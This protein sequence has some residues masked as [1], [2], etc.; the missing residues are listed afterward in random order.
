MFSMYNRLCHLN[1]GTNNVH[2]TTGLDKDDGKRKRN[3]VSYELI[4][5]IQQGV[6]KSTNFVIP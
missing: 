5:S 6:V 1:D 3:A 2:I 4:L